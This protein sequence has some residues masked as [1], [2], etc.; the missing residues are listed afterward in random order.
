MFHP[1][2]FTSNLHACL[3]PAILVDCVG[4]FQIF[5]FSLNSELMRARTWF[6]ITS[7][8]FVPKKSTQYHL[9]H[10]CTFV[11]LVVSM[12][13]KSVGGDEISVFSPVGVARA[14][15]IPVGAL[16]AGDLMGETPRGN[17]A[18][19]AEPAEQMPDQKAE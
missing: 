2:C 3:G 15:A 4:D 6:K 1:C 11:C 12:S 8:S 10:L 16:E 19:Y 5:I 13:A 9:D 18:R 14:A 17:K 7:R